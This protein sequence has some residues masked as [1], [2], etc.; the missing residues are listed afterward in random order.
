MGAD[1]AVLSTGIGY[2]RLMFAGNFTIVLLFIINAI[3]RGAGDAMLALKA[4]WLAKAI[5]IVLDPLLIFGCVAFA[6]GNW[7][8]RVV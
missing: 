2:T 6:R 7:R 1:E 3:F 4:L 8:L 5:N